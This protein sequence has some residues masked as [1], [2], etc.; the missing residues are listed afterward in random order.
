MRER[1]RDRE[2]ERGQAKGYVKKI[3]NFSRSQTP[4][5]GP[6][7]RLAQSENKNIFALAY[8]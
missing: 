5:R 1:K 3:E 6:L 8:L 7:S 2:R 4:F